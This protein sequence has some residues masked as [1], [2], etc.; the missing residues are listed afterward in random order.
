MIFS[1]IAMILIILPSSVLSHVDGSVRGA[2]IRAKNCVVRSVVNASFQ[3]RAWRFH[4][5]ISRKPLNGK[6]YLIGGESLD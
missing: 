4:V 1:A 2:T 6:Q 3:L 5:V